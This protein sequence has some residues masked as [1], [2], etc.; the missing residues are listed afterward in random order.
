LERVSHEQLDVVSIDVVTTDSSQSPTVADFVAALD[1]KNEAVLEYR[2][3][4]FSADDQ[5]RIRTE[6]SRRTQPPP[7]VFRRLWR[8]PGFRGFV[9][10]YVLLYI[11]L[12]GWFVSR[13]TDLSPD[14][15]P[16]THVPDGLERPPADLVAID[17]DSDD[18]DDLVVVDFN[19]ASDPAPTIL[20]LPPK[21]TVR[22]FGEKWGLPIA[23]L[24]IPVLV[25]V[26]T[27]FLNRGS[28]KQV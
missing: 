11:V 24:V 26:M 20:Q 13:Y 2:L 7:G 18:W 16:T 21:P 15:E 4:K 23:G 8:R 28:S 14:D 19:S 25:V 9:I 6:R 22:T 17:L 3:S 5:D 10:V 12:V 27:W 1:E